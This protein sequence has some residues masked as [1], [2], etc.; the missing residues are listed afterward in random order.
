MSR[1]VR[2]LLRICA[3]CVVVAG[4]MP[5]PV[6]RVAAIPP[7]AVEA[8]E[9]L[10]FSDNLV[11]GGAVANGCG[12]QGADGIDVPDEWFGTSFTPACDWHDRCY[13]TVGMSQG[14]CDLGMLAKN[15][16]AC[17]GFGPC[18]LVAVAY[19]AAVAVA[20]FDP[21]MS[22]QA[23]ANE[24]AIRRAAAFIGDPHL[25]TFDGRW[26]SF[27]AAGEFRMAA[28]DTG[29]LIQARF[30]P[31][32][33]FMSMTTGVGIRIGAQRVVVQTDPVTAELTI[34]VDG[35]PID[36]PVVE[37]TD[38][39]LVRDRHVPNARSMVSI[40]GHD[41]LQ[42]D[43]IDYGRYLD[44]VA[45]L[46]V[47]R[48]GTVDGLLG[49]G[50][51]IIGNDPLVADAVAITDDELAAFPPD[52]RLVERY[53]LERPESWFLAGEVDY[54]G[55]EI[56]ALPRNPFDLSVLPPEDVA[57]ATAACTEAG[58]TGRELD[59][60]VLDVALTGDPGFATRHEVAATQIAVIAP[61]TDPGLEPEPEPTTSIAPPAPEAPAD[62]ADLEALCEAIDAADHAGIAA[63]IADGRGIAVPPD[64]TGT[65][66][67]ACALLAADAATVRLLLDAGA[68]PNVSMGG[69]HTVVFAA[70]AGADFVE[71]VLAAGGDPNG[72]VRAGSI[73]S[74]PLG[75]AA[76]MGDVDVV[77]VLLEYGATTDRGIFASDADLRMMIT[78]PVLRELLG[79][80]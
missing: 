48:S 20:G 23:E 2:R 27:M 50:D 49:N 52:P 61:S 24:R 3:V 45:A 38:G 66:P 14:Y 26:Y 6:A 58:L 31:F 15:V 13:G 34:L 25:T 29:D 39:I 44:V 69:T 57:R 55:A 9:Q 35:R 16:V 68:D 78:D 19:A 75:F 80:A 62:E 70:G 4:V 37:L 65:P 60:C 74:T 43:A 40:R 17:Q 8:F 33:D 18:N 28:D 32:N 73:D 59:I 63:L 54:Y 12:S 77:R 71:L 79:I 47:E 67:L 72:G 53:R 30:H 22:G 76:L 42:V 56:L 46:P 11:D 5:S 41:G 10:T 21:Y 7:D 51:G 1:T 64:Y 36:A